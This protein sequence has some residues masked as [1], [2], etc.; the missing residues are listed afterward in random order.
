MSLLRAFGPRGAP[1]PAPSEGGAAASA[2]L[3]RAPRGPVVVVFHASWCPH[4][5]HFMQC[6][7]VDGTRARLRDE[8]GATCIAVQSD[9]SERMD[10]VGAVRAADP[11]AAQA[12]ESTGFAAGGVPCFVVAARG[13][14]GSLRAAS[15]TGD[16][17]PQEFL[18]RAER[19]LS[20]VE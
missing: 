10:L 9:G 19:A 14:D 3:E 13:G 11:Q 12:L 6:T 2:L 4:C 15:F 20:E 17:A 5:T 7:W 18:A 8:L 16:S 1:A